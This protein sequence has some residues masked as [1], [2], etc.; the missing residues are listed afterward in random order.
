MP[1]PHHSSFF[2]G[3]MPFLLPNQRHQSTKG[4]KF[5]VEKNNFFKAH[6]PKWPL[7]KNYIKTEP[8]NYVLFVFKVYDECKSLE[9]KTL[10]NMFFAANLL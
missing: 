1:A 2:T 6:M 3:R 10:V 7:V 5:T 9:N 8:K 4:T